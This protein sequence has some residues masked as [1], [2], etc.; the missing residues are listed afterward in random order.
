[1]KSLGACL[2]LLSAAMIWGSGFAITKDALGTL[3]PC[4]LLLLRFSLASLVM[5][6][7]LWKRL[8]TADRRTWMVGLLAGIFVALGHVFQ[9]F[10]M[11]HTTAGKSAFLTAVYV[12]LV[13]FLLWI[14]GGRV[15][16]RWNIAAACL[17]LAGVGVISLDS[18]LTIGMGEVLAL[19]CG[20]MFALQLVVI[21]L[22]AACD[23][24]V[25]TWLCMFTS[26]LVAAPLVL[27]SEP[28]PQTISMQ[29]FVSVAYLA[30]ACSAYGFTAQNI[31]VKYAPAA[32]ATILLS[33][34][35]VF[36]CVAGVLFL[37]EPVN[38]RM[39][40]GS[41]MILSSLL[42]SNIQTKKI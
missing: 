36:A 20:L 29:N 4:F 31:G 16:T 13:P 5:L 6:P 2:L 24:W 9:N 32:V 39:L 14:A 11:K 28:V 7:F 15:P 17:C 35:A 40:I 26:A 18:D 25:V 41:G 33:M 38:T 19:I 34:E 3:P 27:L 8:R 1:M 22:H 12:V 42:I 23:M 37:H 30:V 21:N 10:G